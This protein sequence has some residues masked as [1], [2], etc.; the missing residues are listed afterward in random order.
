M[1]S[2]ESAHHDVICFMRAKDV[3]LIV[4]EAVQFFGMKNSENITSVPPVLPKA[5]EVYLFVN[6]DPSKSS[7]KHAYIII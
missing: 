7:I 1:K 5:G 3:E 4:E 6:D 2:H